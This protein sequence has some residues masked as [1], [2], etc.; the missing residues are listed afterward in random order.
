MAMIQC[1]VFKRMNTVYDGGVEVPVTISPKDHLRNLC[2]PLI[3]LSTSPVSLCYKAI[4]KRLSLDVSSTYCLGISLVPR[5]RGTKK[6]HNSKMKST[7]TKLEQSDINL[8]VRKYS[9][10]F[11]ILLGI[12]N[13]KQ[14]NKAKQNLKNVVQL[15]C[16]NLVLCRTLECHHFLANSV[17]KNYQ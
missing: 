15:Q 11:H 14:T 13:L 16:R 8:A 5:S 10:Q 3:M 7:A 2:S 4:A 1:F 12:F 9:I 17:A 6:F